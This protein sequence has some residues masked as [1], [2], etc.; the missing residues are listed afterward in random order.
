MDQGV[1]KILE[2]IGSYANRGILIGGHQ[3]EVVDIFAEAVAKV[4]VSKAFELYRGMSICT[5][6]ISWIL[7]KEFGPELVAA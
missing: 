4:G 6:H 3:Q 2:S 1:L 5:P 7:E